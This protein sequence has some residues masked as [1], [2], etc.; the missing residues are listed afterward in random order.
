MWAPAT[1]GN[2][3]ERSFQ[4]YRECRRT[5]AWRL[6]MPAPRRG[7]RRTG[8]PTYTD[9]YTYVGRYRHTFVSVTSS[10]TAAR[11]LFYFLLFPQRVSTCCLVDLFFTRGGIFERNRIGGEFEIHQRIC[12]KK[13][14]Q[15]SEWNTFGHGQNDSPKKRKRKKNHLK[16]M[17]EENQKEK[18]VIF[19]W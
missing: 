16:E 18:K 14:E 10:S 17:M 12:L 15:K 7:N 4:E 9:V 5:W 1:V 13:G 19:G 8:I 11:I 6:K 2:K 3:S